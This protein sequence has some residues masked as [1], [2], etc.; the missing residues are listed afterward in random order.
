MNWPGEDI[1]EIGSNY[2]RKIRFN[3]NLFKPTEICGSGSM[4][5]NVTVYHIFQICLQMNLIPI[6]ILGYRKMRCGRFWVE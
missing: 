6:R 2:F 5:I 4:Q 1:F 3:H